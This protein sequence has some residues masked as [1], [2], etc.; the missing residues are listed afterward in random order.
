MSPLATF[1]ESL[2]LQW[3]DLID[4]LL[5]SLIFYRLLIL[6]KG[7]RTIPMLLGFSL[8]LGLYVLSLALQLDAT[9][10][11]LDNLA[12]SLV[13]VVVVLF[14][15]DIRNALAQFGLFTMFR[16]SRAKQQTI[17]DTV[18]QAC[19]T[20]A[21]RRIGALIV[22][23]REVGLRN[24]T[25]RGTMLNAEVSEPLLLS[26]FAPTSPLHDGAVVLSPKGVLVAARC[27]LP[28]SMNTR[29]S[30]DLGT[31]HR[32]AVGVTEESDAI[33]L[34]VS[35]ERREI[36]LCFRGSILRNQGRQLRPLV[37]DLLS[38]KLTELPG[39]EKLENGDDPAPPV[40]LEEAA[41][42]TAPQTTP[43]AS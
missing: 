11:L 21:R 42:A 23:E 30:E 36:S 13:L 10:L 33:V 26:L 37:L 41:P 1:I 6:I 20:M 24:H 14:Q 19:E 9:L 15:A 28:V 5:L 22:F 3:Q 17:V 16:D 34:V 8:L 27:I 7:T 32:A 38:G 31:R 12:N 4:L 35:E 18:L 40:I 25:D 2:D 29:L 43:A 39:A